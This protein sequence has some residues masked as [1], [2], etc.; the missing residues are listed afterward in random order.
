MSQKGFDFGFSIQERFALGTLQKAGVM[1]KP[2][3]I[4]FLSAESSVV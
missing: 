3:D 2:V 1:L 4:G